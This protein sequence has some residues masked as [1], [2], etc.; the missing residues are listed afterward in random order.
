MATLV[1]YAAG[2]ENVSAACLAKY[3]VEDRGWT[4]ICSVLVFLM[5]TGFAFLEAGGP[6][7]LASLPPPSSTDLTPPL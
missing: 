7:P 2:A 4:I 3:G 1:P 5:Q 6:P